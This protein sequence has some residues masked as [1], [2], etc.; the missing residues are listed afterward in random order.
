MEYGHI[1]LIVLLFEGVE[2]GSVGHE[3]HNA[4]LDAVVEEVVIHLLMLASNMVQLASRKRVK[5]VGWLAQIRNAEEWV[6]D[7]ILTLH[8]TFVVIVEL[9][10]GDGHMTHLVLPLAHLFHVFVH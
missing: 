10:E 4:L 3:N 1:M 6:I 9:L 2:V 8:C 7:A 5:C